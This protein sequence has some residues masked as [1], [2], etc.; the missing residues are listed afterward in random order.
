MIDFLRH[1]D[2]LEMGGV[3]RE[4]AS[5]GAGT[6]PQRGGHPLADDHLTTGVTARVPGPEGPSGEQRNA[7]EVEEVRADPVH[8]Y[9]QAHWRCARRI[10]PPLTVR[11]TTAVR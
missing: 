7:V 4:R 6:R 10:G 2:D 11:M 9:R 1:R 3:V 5:H 8:V